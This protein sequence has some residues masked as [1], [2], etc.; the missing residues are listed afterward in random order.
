MT[1]TLRARDMMSVRIHTVAA[2]DRVYAAVQTLLKKR[3][4][5][6]PVVDQNN[7]VIGI[8]S[9]KDCIQAML[10]AINDRLPPSL[11]RDVMTTSVVTAKPDDDLLSIAHIFLTRPIRRIPVVDEQ[12]KLLGQIS[13]RD[14][15]AAASRVFDEAPSRDA[16]VL[17]LSA[18]GRQAPSAVRATGRTPSAPFRRR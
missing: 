9:E 16:A 1:D 4:S 14:L 2:E 6:A 13:R 3:V 10:R 11:V 18:T 7:R 5:G 17:Y 8:L 15:L 12:G